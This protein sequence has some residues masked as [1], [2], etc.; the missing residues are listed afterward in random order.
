ML[1]KKETETSQWKSWLYIL[2]KRIIQSWRTH[3]VSFRS[4]LDNL[5]YCYHFWKYRYKRYKQETSNTRT[6]SSLLLISANFHVNCFAK[7]WGHKITIHLVPSRLLSI[8]KN[9]NFGKRPMQIYVLFLVIYVHSIK[10]KSTWKCAMHFMLNII[11]F[12]LPLL[13]KGGKLLQQQKVHN[14]SCM[15]I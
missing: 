11:Y 14:I 13:E 4:N 8:L 12:N 10:Y 2:S 1:L 6:L 7:L 3:R 9:I 15:I 5:L